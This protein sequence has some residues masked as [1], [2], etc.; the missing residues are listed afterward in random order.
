MLNDAASVGET[1]IKYMPSEYDFTHIK[2][3]RRFWG[4][5]FGLAYK[6]LRMDADLYHV[7]YLLQD[8]FFAQK[9]GKHP[10]IGHAHGSD[11]RDL[12]H[13][14]RYGWIVKSNLKNCDKVFVTQP[15]ILET[16][17]QYN[18]TAEYLPI[19]FDPEL[20]YPKPFVPKKR[21]V[22]F[23]PSTLNHRTKGPGEFLLCLEGVKADFELVLFASGPDYL[24]V[25]S[26]VK[27]Y[28]FRARFLPPVPH[29]VMNLLYWDADLVLGAFSYHKRP[30]R[31]LDTVCVE[32][33]ACGRPVISYLAEGFYGDV[34]LQSYTVQNCFD[35]VEGAMNLFLSD[36]VAVNEQVARQLGYVN[37]VHAAPI[38][39]SRL[40][41]VYKNMGKC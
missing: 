4:K 16:A 5:S 33:M 12:I 19:P 35:K 41:E 36:E 20:F 37:R 27:R 7:H 40:A 28:G 22:V 15:T 18:K 6:A 38:V 1:L 9:F 30:V 14:K 34:P 39:A 23:M 2:R 3:S 8:C 24:D 32:A 21:K 31:Q 29:E 10:L 25:K 11:L 26:L 13:S 17:L